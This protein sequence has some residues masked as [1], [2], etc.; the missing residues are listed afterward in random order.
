MFLLSPDVER[1]L[2]AGARDFSLKKVK[3]V[4]FTC[5]ILRIIFTKLLSWRCLGSFCLLSSSLQLPVVYKTQAHFILT[6]QTSY[7]NGLPVSGWRRELDTGPRRQTVAIWILF[8]SPVLLFWSYPVFGPGMDGPEASKHGKKSTCQKLE[9]QKKVD[10]P[11]L[12]FCYSTGCCFFGVTYAG[13][14][15]LFPKRRAHPSDSFCCLNPQKLICFKS[16]IY[17]G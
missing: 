14:V 11:L 8:R 12:R 17:K 5:Y 9:D 13:F 3:A 15:T 7:Y 1:T 4:I 10:K 6:V 2:S 16:A